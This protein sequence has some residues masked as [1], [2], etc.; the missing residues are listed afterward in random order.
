MAL[1]KCPRCGKE[2]S[3][4]AEKCPYCGVKCQEFDSEHEKVNMNCN[5]E[6]PKKFFWKNILI[7]VLSGLCIISIVVNIVQFNRVN[8]LSDK[9]K[10]EN[11]TNGVNDI[12]AQ[13]KTTEVSI[14]DNSSNTPSN[15]QE[16]CIPEEADYSFLF[17]DEQLFIDCKTEGVY[18]V[19]V[20]LEPG[21]YLVYGL[22]ADASY[23]IY[24]SEDDKPYNNCIYSIVTL[25]ENEYI[26]LYYDSILIS[27]TQIQKDNMKQYGMFEVGKDIP[28]G[29]YKAVSISNEYKGSLANISGITGAY[30]IKEGNEQIKCER[31]NGEQT[32]INVKEGQI[33]FLVN[34]ALYKMG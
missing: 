8:L 33:L 24:T 17:A 14:T 6:Q 3:D 28:A 30:E 2:I 9:T 25:K 1:I 13:E 26:E 10:S 20:D 23:S 31:I 29:E 4:K 19:G 22:C 16:N 32:Y 21:N 15:T 12:D 27:E 11:T 5:S 7:G 34:I 18:K